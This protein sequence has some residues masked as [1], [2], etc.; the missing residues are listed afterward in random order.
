MFAE[1]DT[2]MNQDVLLRQASAQRAQ[3]SGAHWQNSTTSVSGDLPTCVLQTRLVTGCP[4]WDHAR[5]DALTR[6]LNLDGSLDMAGSGSGFWARGSWTVSLWAAAG[7]TC[8]D[9]GERR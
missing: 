8:C 3:C 4:A 1:D 6:R 9:G 5:M 7:A 2:P